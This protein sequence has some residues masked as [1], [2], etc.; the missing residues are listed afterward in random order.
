MSG[1]AVLL[2]GDV[3]DKLR[4]MDS[5]SVQCAVTSPP[6][7]GLR[8]Y[9]LPPS[10]WGGDAEHEH[11]WGAEIRHVGGAG[12]QGKT[13]QRAGR[14]NVTEQEKVRD[15]GA[16]C[17]CGAWRGCLGL[18][19]TPEL[20]IEHMVAVFREVRRVLR[21]DGTLW[22]NI[23]DSYA[24]SGRGG[25]PEAG[26]KQGTNAGSQSVGVLYGREQEDAAAERARIKEQFAATKVVGIKSKDLVGIPWMLA[27]ALRADG[28]YLRSEIIWA[29]PNPMPESVTDRPTK[30][31]ETI[32]LFAKSAKYF[33][34]AE[35]IKEPCSP[36]TATVKT[37][38]RKGNGTESTGEKLNLWMETNGGR[39]NPEK[40]NKRSV[41]TI[42]PQPFRGAHFA[43]F[44]E[45][46]VE[47]CVLAGS[48]PGDLVLD[49]FAGSC[50][51]A[52]VAL[53]HGRSF[54]GIELSTA[55]AEIARKRVADS[56][57][58]ELLV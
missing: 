52:V 19:P 4:E 58:G 18:E 33:Y 37:T 30:A 31:H 23:G 53:R 6:Y 50:T 8:D 24:G 55:Y 1:C 36:K 9:G 41:W 46:L 54:V 22:L 17:S 38:P 56:G 42:P 48:A 26:T 21:D 39:Y 15:A 10:I 16:F 2:V 47:P 35:A 20:Y 32:F 13:S 49:P 14:S 51:T 25:N 28:W 57:E 43:T 5:E 7:W 3:L 11:E 12:V 29:K 44:P 45:R 27:F 34:D 40:A